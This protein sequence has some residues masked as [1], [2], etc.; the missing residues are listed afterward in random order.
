MKRRCKEE[1]FRRES[2]TLKYS[3]RREK[4]QSAKYFISSKNHKKWKED[5]RR[6]I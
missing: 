3:Q 1:N 4:L 2:D 6:V 5:G